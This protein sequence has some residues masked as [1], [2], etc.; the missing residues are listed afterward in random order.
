MS[1]LI[2]A[3]RVKCA[4]C[5]LDAAVRVHYARLNLCREHF[6]EYVENRVVKT[7]QYYGL[8]NGAR[9]ILVALSGGK[10][11][12]SLARILSRRRGE[13]GIEKV[14]GL[15]LDLGLGDYSRASRTAV[16]KLC[17]ELNLMCI[18]LDLRDLVG[19]SLPELVSLTKRPACSLCGMLKRY[20]VNAAAVELNV[21]AVALGHHLDDLLVFA[22]KN[23]L[24]QQDLNQL[25]LSPIAR[26]SPGLLATKLKVLYEIYESDLKLYADLSGIEYV[27]IP[28]PFKYVDTVQEA[29]RELLEKLESSSPGFKVSLIRRLSRLLKSEEELNKVM[30]CKYCGMP[31]STGTCALCKLTTRVHGK[32][33]GSEVR[34]KVRESVVLLE[35][36]ESLHT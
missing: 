31:T 33:L 14:Y 11:S 28:C 1:T 34:S 27:R 4:K 8:F 9:R 7:S 21:D 16:E 10:D 25:K 3:K 36:H 26:G 15:H 13:L 24:T 18:F 5:D 32:P 20:I 17:K 2:T 35:K 12:L 29:V 19:Y 22:L 6:L 23:I 30:Q